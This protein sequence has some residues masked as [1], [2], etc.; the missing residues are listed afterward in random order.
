MILPTDVLP[1]HSHIPTSEE[2]AA[3]ALHVTKEWLPTVD[4]DDPTEVVEFRAKVIDILFYA[5]SDGLGTAAILDLQEIARRCERWV[6][7]SIRRAQEQGRVRGPGKRDPTLRTSEDYAGVRI[8]STLSPY[9]RWLTL[10]DNNF[11]DLLLQG[12]ANGTLAQIPLMAIARTF[13]GV[14]DK[15]ERRR[16]RIIA[17]AEQQMTTRQIARAMGMTMDGLSRI[18][19]A[20]GIEIPAD[21]ISGRRTRRIDPR[22]VVSEGIIALEGVAMG[23]GLI[24]SDDYDSLDP[25]EVDNWLAALSKTLP[26]INAL[27]KELNRVHDQ[28]S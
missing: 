12:R 18:I 5:R 24:E 9:Y 19:A 8:P 22:R 23:L 3:A 14:S 15:T 20:A 6:A 16:Q 7:I 2:V 21:E 17:F 25:T 11:E 4:L 10:S 1:P 26:A 13:T 27:R 28:Q